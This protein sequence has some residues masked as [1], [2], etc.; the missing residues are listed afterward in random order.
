[1]WLGFLRHKF[2]TFKP[3]LWLITALGV[4]VPKRLRAEWR[5]EWQAELRS[6][7]ALLEDWDR[8]NWQTRLDLLWRSL[9]AFRDALV[10]QPRRL[11]EEMFHDIRIGARTLAGDPG[12]T[13]IALIT[14]ALGIGANT[15]IFSVVNALILKPLPYANPDRLVWIGE[16]SPDRPGDFVPG[17]HFLEWT[18]Q[19]E[20]LEQIAAY[21]PTSAILTGAG[22]PERLDANRV[23]A[24]FFAALGVRLALGRAFV[25]QDDLPGAAPVAIISHSLWQRRFGADPNVIGRSIQLDDKSYTVV[26]VLPAGFRFSEP[27]ELWIPLA[28]DPKQERGNVMTSILS[29]FGR[30][31][32]GVTRATAESELDTIRSRYEASRPPNSLAFGGAVRLM[33]LHQ[34]LVGDTGRLLLIL[35]GAVSLIL[36]IACAN[37]ANLL[38]SRGAGRQKEFAIR[39]A[40]GAGRL[41]LM[42]QMITE[43]LLLAVCGGV[44]GLCLG[45]LLTKGV[46]SLASA[47]TLGEISRV[48]TI[49][50]DPRVLGFTLI[51]SLITGLLF[52][53]APALQISSPALNDSLKEG[54]RGSR[55]HRGGVRQ[56]LMV[57]EVALSIVLLIGAGL[58]IR[59]FANLLRVNPGYRPDNLLTMRLSLPEPRY[60]ERARRE[61][62][63]SEILQR[64]SGLPGVQSVG[65]INHLPLTDFMLG[66]WLRIPGRPVTTNQPPTPMAIVSPDYFRAIGIPL[67]AGREFTDR[68]DSQSPRVL[69]LSES[70][71]SACFPG[72]NPLG[73]QV[74][75]PGPGKDTPTVV[76]VVGDIRHKGLDQDVTP[77]V[78]QPYRQFAPGSMALVIRAARPM[79]LAPAVRDQVLAID[80]ALA[81]GEIQTMQQRLSGSTSPRRL[82]LMLL[83]LF[84]T[85][86]LAL[87]AVGVYGVIAYVGAQ[88]KHEIGIRMALG[89]EAADVRRLLIGQGM[90]LVGAGVLLGLGAAL[91]LTRV[92]NSLLFGVSATDPLTLAGVSVL[93]A[94][95]GLAACYKPAR[96]AARV[97]PMA[98]L[99]CD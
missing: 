29:S 61:A 43:S 38:L 36:L 25:A 64:I 60:E 63:Y 33:S 34:K 70:L 15:A 80:Q 97:D 71:A 49:D 24:G 83:G 47:A 69:I 58:L 10:L 11:E 48:E 62:F 95:V 96:A 59:S 68:D 76:G 14:L 53:L 44:V 46:V 98:A 27:F 55:F 73:K 9:G 35:L 82:N 41:R 18:E 51:V 56:A 37:V 72:E 90:I 16:V 75:V 84:A 32:P 67:R 2:K 74:W 30:L 54:G 94:I 91:G 78:Y 21:N 81:V 7:E 28:L 79:G 20:T 87:S 86:A 52:G 39:A 17:A 57:T 8:L 6:R 19:S 66:G 99:R 23:S 65:A 40:L 89:A 4:I 1:V 85:L 77:Q 26:G 50:I 22:E 3:Y 93:L 31:R 12:F 88:R 13:A 5:Q 92:M 42:R 45:F